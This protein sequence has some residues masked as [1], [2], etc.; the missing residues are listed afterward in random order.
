MPLM[1]LFAASLREPLWAEVHSYYFCNYWHQA[2]GISQIPQ[3][4]I[5]I[6]ETFAFPCCPN[7]FLMC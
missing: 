6:L 7:H 2:S 1:W 4:F 3:F 5:F